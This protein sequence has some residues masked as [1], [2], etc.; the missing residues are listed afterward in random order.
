MTA[1]MSDSFLLEEK[2]FLLVGVNGSGLFNPSDHNMQPLPRIT[3]CWRGYVCTY[4]VLQN[5]L[6]LDSLLI[7]LDHEGPAIKD[8]PPVFSNQGTFN[9]TYSDLD[10]HMDFTG[11]LLIA[12][13]FIQQLY[14]HMGFH[15]AWKYETVFELTVANGHVLETKDVS[16]NM[17]GLR[18]KM[19]REPLQP[20]RDASKQEIESWI[21]STFK[22]NHRF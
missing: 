13:G 20:N 10:L 12:Q 9:N 18:D 5:E 3:S 1:Q 15:P 19:S 4:K 8:I 11:D 21:E 2:K 6:L 14:V 22:R 7:N 16:E 17:A